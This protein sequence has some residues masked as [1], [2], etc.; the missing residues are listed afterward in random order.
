MIP[1]FFSAIGKEVRGMHEAAYVLAGFALASQLLALL[2]DR[3]LAASFGASHTL[4]L[5]YAAFRVPDFLFATVASLLSL[6]ALLPVLSRLQEREEG[7]VISF[8]RDTLVVFLV[9]MSLLAGILFIFAPL[10]AIGV[11]PGLTTDP[12][13]H[14]QLILLIRIL[15]LQPIFLGASNTLASFTQLRHRFILY[16][17]SPLLYNLGIIFGAVVLYPYFGLA[18]LGWG[19]VFGAVMH[20]SIQ[21]PFFFSEK[22]SEHM[23][24]NTLLKEFSQVL[25]LSVPRTLSLAAGQ[26]SLLAL[27]ALASLLS[28]GSIAIFTF[29]YN[30]QAVP[31]TV[32]GVSYSIA[33]FPTLARLHAQGNTHEFK[34]HIEAA[35]RH[36]LFWSIP[37]MVFVIVMRAQLVRVILGAGAFNWDDT[38]LTAAALALFIISIA[39]QSMSLV[40]ARAYF[41]I[42]NTRKPF[43]FGLI[44]VVVSIGSSIAFIALFHSSVFI[45]NFIEAL[46]RVSDIPGTTV[47]MLAL[48]F[49][50]GSIAEFAVTFVFFR[51]DF[52]ISHGSIVRLTFQ[53]FSA[54]VLGAAVTYGILFL[55]GV[56]GTIDKTLILVLQGALAGTVG[57]AVTVFFL[58]LL[59]NP[60]LHEALAA[61]MRRFIDA[62]PVVLEPSDISS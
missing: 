44:D 53:S 4:D 10:L 51:R 1:R 11:A 32:I 28:A 12:T 40:I 48:G 18:G 42:G 39:A 3:I 31:L 43:Y 59:K 15:L 8:L 25:V 9:G 54:S 7:M 41:A 14:A 13:S 2:R 61:L 60:E 6:Y 29:A 30:L 47:L 45:R 33:V 17:V 49:A 19:V 22:A 62:P 58:W 5:Y 23:P 57:L 27:V 46:F 24:L 26:I 55:T 56:A 35:L 36:V 50:C 34:K 21:L 38:R 52:G 37:V 20:M 16:S